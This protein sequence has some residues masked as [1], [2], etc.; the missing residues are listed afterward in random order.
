MSERPNINLIKPEK[1]I[2]Q[3]TDEER[4]AFADRIFDILAEQ[5][6][7]KPGGSEGQSA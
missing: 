3:M 6:T 4:E 5:R 1:P 7:D 2:S